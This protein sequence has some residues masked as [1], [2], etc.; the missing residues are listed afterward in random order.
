MH[1]AVAHHEGTAYVSASRFDWDDFR[2]YVYK[3]TDYGKHWTQITAGLP[4]GQYVESVRQDPDDAQ[5]ALRGH[6]RDG[7]LQSGRGRAVAAVDPESA[8]GAG[9]RCRDTARAA[10]NRA[11]HIRARFLGA[12]TTCSSS[13]SWGLRKWPPD[14]LSLFKPQQA[15]LVTRRAGGF[16]RRGTGGEN[17]APGATVVFHLPANYDGS[18]PVTLSFSDATGKLIHSYPLHLKTKASRAEF[19][20]PRSSAKTTRKKV[21]R[22]RT[23]HE[24]LPVGSDVLGCG[25]REGHLQFWLYGRSAHRS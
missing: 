11:R 24:P 17:L 18:T 8:R 5:P 12:W 22:D 1:R 25:G 2:P 6:K 23:W 3:T 7:V 4:E 16:G 21:D 14:A 20:H 10:R 15:W 13:S 19:E 9:E